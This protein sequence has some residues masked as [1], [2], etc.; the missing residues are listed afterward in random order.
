M[1]KT[2]LKINGQ[3]SQ[4]DR[5]QHPPCLSPCHSTV[6]HS[7]KGAAW[8]PGPVYRLQSRWSHDLGKAVLEGGL[9]PLRLASTEKQTGPRMK[10]PFA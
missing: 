6:S 2:G 5:W 10:V 4:P 1:I 9:E 8:L 7:V 3:G